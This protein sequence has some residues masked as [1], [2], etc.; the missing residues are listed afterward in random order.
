ME[1]L[2]GEFRPKCSASPATW[3]RRPKRRPRR[4]FFVWLPTFTVDEYR[5]VLDPAA[6]LAVANR[7]TRLLS[8]HGQSRSKLNEK[9]KGV[10]AELL[11]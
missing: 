9:L 10:H 6:Q 1:S 11:G 2:Q 8:T 7:R 4:C 5:T 3:G